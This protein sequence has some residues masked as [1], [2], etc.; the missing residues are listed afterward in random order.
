MCLALCRASKVQGD[1]PELGLRM[2]QPGGKDCQIKDSSGVAE[3]SSGMW[4]EYN[5]AREG[6]ALGGVGGQNLQ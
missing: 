3:A 6:F 4:K 2:L 1:S 5:R